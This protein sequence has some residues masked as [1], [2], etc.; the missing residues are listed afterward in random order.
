ME[1]CGLDGATEDGDTLHKE[2]Q[3]GRMTRDENDV[4]KII[5]TLYKFFNPF[6]PASKQP[7][8]RLTHLSSAIE[9]S[10]ETASDLLQAEDHGRTRFQEF[11]RDRLTTSDSTKAFH[12]PLKKLNLSTFSVK[13]SKKSATSHSTEI[14]RSDR[15]TFSRIALIAQTRHMD[16]RE[17]FS[18]PLGPVPWA[19]ATPSGTLVKTS[20][21][22]LLPLLTD[23][24][25][26][27]AAVG[28]SSGALMLDGMAM[29][30][31]RKL[32][33]IPA[34]FGE[35][36]ESTFTQMCKHFATYSRVDFIADTYRDVSIKNLER[37]ARSAQGALRQHISSPQQRTPHQF[38]KYLA[39]GANKEELLNFF[40]TQWQRPDL[41]RRLPPGEI[42][43]ITA[44]RSC[45]MIPSHSSTTECKWCNAFSRHENRCPV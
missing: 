9:A 6:L 45:A 23:G 8:S 3:A 16:M 19:L 43:V 20:K 12:D 42:L 10:A 13:K 38:S 7:Y 33:D 27:P 21:S 44:S 15:A 31:A 32:S 39:V 1:H 29:L 37:T 5:D 24:M 41:V 14:L 17:V 4:L 34:T 35:F 26:Q 25:P 22:S 18:Y 28:T 36:A 11:I 30:R 2:K 40:F